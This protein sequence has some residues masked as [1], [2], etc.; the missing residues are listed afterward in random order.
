MTDESEALSSW[1]TGR[2]A[3]AAEPSRNP[4]EIQLTDRLRDDLVID[5]LAFLE[6][7]VD[8]EDVF[9]A[10]MDEGDLLLGGYETVDDLISRVRVHLGEN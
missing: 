8:L 7:M 2:L 5:S 10:R 1:L 6:L 9:G 4:E 3:K